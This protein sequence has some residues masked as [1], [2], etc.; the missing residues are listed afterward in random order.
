MSST[1]NR[2]HPV[3]MALHW[4]IA[5]SIIFMIGL[6]LIMEDITPISSRF[7]WFQTHKSL[8]LIVLLLSIARLAWRLSHRAPA[9]PEHMSRFEKLAAHGTHW[10]FYA[11]MIGMPLSGWAMVSASG[12][13]P[14]IFFGLFTVPHLPIADSLREIVGDIA[15]EG[16]EILAIYIAIPLIAMHALAA[17]KHQ[18]ID[19]DNLFARM[20]PRFMIKGE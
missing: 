12:K 5:I 11:L 3:A 6:G 13:Y 19:K 1:T 17:L 15:H 2:Y 9:L 4:L 14:T 18:F 7:E 20:L 10:F 16:H 8:G